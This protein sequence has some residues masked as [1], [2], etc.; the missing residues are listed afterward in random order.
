MAPA[1]ARAFAKSQ[2]GGGTILPSQGLRLRLGARTPT[3]R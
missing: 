3:S 1:F 2:L